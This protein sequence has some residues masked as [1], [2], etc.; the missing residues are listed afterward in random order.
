MLRAA[1]ARGVRLVFVGSGVR[2]SDDPGIHLRPIN[3]SVNRDLQHKIIDK[4]PRELRDNV[5][6]WRVSRVT[7]HAKIV[8]IDD[9]FACIGSANMFS[10]SMSGTDRELSTAIITTSSLVK[11]L[12][13]QLDDEHRSVLRPVP[14]RRSIRSW[15]RR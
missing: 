11:D 1:A 14:P 2:D 15:L 8:L 9:V 4:L 12:R 10:R 6:V 5:S 3:R 7:V 13:A